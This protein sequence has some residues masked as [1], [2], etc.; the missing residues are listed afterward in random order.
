MIKAEAGGWGESHEGEQR[1]SATISEVGVQEHQPAVNGEGLEGC[2][3]EA[4]SAR[5]TQ[6][7]THAAAILPRKV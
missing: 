7:C 6:H 5:V 1:S 4:G 2:S 3:G